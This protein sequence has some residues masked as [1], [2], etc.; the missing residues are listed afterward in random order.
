MEAIK[1][2]FRQIRQQGVTDGIF[3]TLEPLSKVGKRDDA[4]GRLASHFAS[5]LWDWRNDRDYLAGQ[6]A[7]DAK[8]L[9][10]NVESINAGHSTGYATGFLADTARTK[11]YA[12]KVEAMERQISS[13]AYIAG[14]D[15]DDLMAVFAL[16]AA[17][18]R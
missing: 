13:L 11:E 10:S 16:I 2:A 1:E 18:S 4:E 12:T 8:R 15:M 9:L 7:S 14:V 3:A 6:M 17:S 5:C